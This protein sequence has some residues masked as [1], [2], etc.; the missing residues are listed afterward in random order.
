M[1][2]WARSFEFHPKEILSPKTTKELQEIIRRAYEEK[3]IVRTRG[4]G[5]SWTGLIKSANFFVHLDEM[6]GLISVDKENNRAR[7]WAGTKLSLFGEEAFKHGMA[8]ANQG[9]INRQS[10]AGACTTG[11]HGTGLTLQSVSNQVSQMTLVTGQGEILDI[12]QNKNSELLKA[13]GVSFGSLGII[14]EMSMNLLP[15]YKLKVETFAEDMKTALSKYKERLQ[16]NRHLEMFYFPMGDWSMVKMMNMTDEEVSPRGF[17]HKFNDIVLENWLY[18]LL[19]ILATKTKSYK[20]LDQLM[21]KFVSHN[22]KVAW[23]HQ[24]FPTDRN[25]RFMEMEYNLPTEKFEEVLEEIKHTIKTHNFQTLFPIEIRFV[26]GDELWLSPAYQRDSVYFAIH[27]YITE[28]YRPYF[29]EVEKIFRKHQGRPHWGK[30]H[31]S[32]ASYFEQV[33]PKWQDFLK[34]RKELDPE[35]VLLNEHLKEV[36]LN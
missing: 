22:T 18:E 21:R 34:L 24:A 32:T 29:N 36:F 26:K 25:I 9:D 10:L 23:S 33:Y 27:T 20:S 6:Q 35:G 14:S 7:A 31:T 16:E 4:S 2:N 13:A 3:S 1:K 11:T 17:S 12:D 8:M 19:N 28:N 5:H 15:A 30:W